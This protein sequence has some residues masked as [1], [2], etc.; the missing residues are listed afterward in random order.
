VS[1]AW[2]AVAHDRS[3]TRYVHLFATS[4]D[5]ALAS[6]VVTACGVD[7]YARFPGEDVRFAVVPEADRC[8]QC[9]EK[10]AAWQ[11]GT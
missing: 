11:H 2:F 9:T 5:E 10:E 4:T 3:R 6:G 8:P 1:R 7:A